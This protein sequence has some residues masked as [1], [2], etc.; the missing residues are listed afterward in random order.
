MVKKDLL[1]AAQPFCDASFTIVSCKYTTRIDCHNRA[2]KTDKMYIFQ[3]LCVEG[4]LY[5]CLVFWKVFD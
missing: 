1:K 4:G 3:Y 5:V 2:R